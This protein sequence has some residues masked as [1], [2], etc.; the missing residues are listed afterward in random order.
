MK[1]TVLPFFLIGL[2]S[3]T[4]SLGQVTDAVKATLLNQHNHYRGA[5]S[6]PNVTWSDAIAAEAQAHVEPCKFAL[7]ET[8]H[9]QILGAGVFSPNAGGVV[10]YWYENGASRYN[11]GDPGFSSETGTFTQ[12]V[13]VASKEIG[14]GV[15]RCEG[16]NGV[17][18][19]LIS[20]FYSPPGN[21]IGY[22][23]TNVRPPIPPNGIPVSR[24]KSKR[25]FIRLALAGWTTLA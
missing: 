14:C 6:A 16:L 11:Y 22:F 5:H 25:E 2:L 1:F 7:A 15:K 3:A 24:R 4:T 20:C 13:W 21:V 8:R 12:I 17:P 19:S 23:G 18:G 10:R 9:G